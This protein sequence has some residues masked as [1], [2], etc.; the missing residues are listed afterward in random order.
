M[1]SLPSIF[2]LA[3]LPIF[4]VLG[5]QSASPQQDLVVHEWGT[6]TTVA[7]SDGA[8]LEWRP[9]L[10]KTSDLP[11]FVYGSGRSGADAGL[12]FGVL[13]KVCGHAGCGCGDHCQPDDKGNCNCKGCIK[14]TVRME[15]P[16]IYFYTKKKQRV[17]LRV[18]FPG[19]TITEWYP[20]A[21]R[22][23]H[24]ID[25][26][27]I[28]LQPDYE[29]GFPTE[30]GRN[31]YYPAR[32]TDAVPV[33]ICSSNKP[34]K[35]H[36]KFLFY[37]GVGTFPLP[38]EASLVRDRLRLENRSQQIVPAVLV[39]DHR[40]DQI[41]ISVL[42]QRT[43]GKQILDL[44]GEIS[45]TQTVQKI[46]RKLLVEQGLYPKEA[47]AMVQTWK[48][49]WFT[50]GLRVF[51]LLPTQAT[52]AILPLAITPKPKAIVRVL[53]GR[54]EILTQKRRQ[55]IR[56]LATGLGD[57]DFGV[58]EK[59]T[60]ALIRVGRFAAPVLEKILLDCKDLEVKARIRAILGR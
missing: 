24:G 26:G 2:C 22:I 25:W 4:A 38:L 53:V 10:G 19:G 27:T 54:I 12:R 45:N 44:P 13:C 43:P 9:L 11:G 40:Q 41:R 35:E 8:A 47:R 29:G 37:R 17:S 30:P 15:T 14:G 6:F 59:A 28:E 31:H 55:E 3:A 7:G 42:K 34:T 5:F 1:K 16:V 58:R 60:Q 48:D 46:L 18:D 36:E 56:K 49:H 20:K 21:R 57:P 50:K 39:F 33:Q 51:Y 32:E 52:E 23:D